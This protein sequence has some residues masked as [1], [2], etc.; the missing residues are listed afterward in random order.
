[1]CADE[2][3]PVIICP[4]DQTII[5]DR[6]ENNALVTWKVPIAIDNSRYYTSVTPIPALIPPARLPIGST[7]MTYTAADNNQNKAKCTF[8]ITV[9]GKSSMR[10]IAFPSVIGK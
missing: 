8:T 1:M 2:T 4:L 7:V 9:L 3:P 5:A 10:K 6:G